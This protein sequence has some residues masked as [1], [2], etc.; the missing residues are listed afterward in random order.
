[1]ASKLNKGEK[2]SLNR[3]LLGTFL[4]GLF[5]NLISISLAQIFYSLNVVLGLFL[6]FR[7]ERPFQVPSFFWPLIIY[8][9]LSLIASLLSVNPGLSF[10]DCRELLLFLLIPATV[11]TLTSSRSLER[12]NQIILASGIINFL[13]SLINYLIS[14]QKGL[15]LRGF[16]GHYMTEAGLLMLLIAFCGAQFLFCREKKRWLWAAL[17][18]GSGYL[19]LLTLT[20]NAWLGLASA[21]LLL[22]V[23]WRPIALIFVP[24]FV[25]AIYL[26]SPMEVKKRITNTFNFYSPSSRQRIEYYRAGL[27]IIGD[28]PLFGCGPDTVELVF[29]HPKYGLSEQAKL[30]VH[31]H[32]NLLQ[33]AA[34]RGLATLLA[35]LIFIFWSFWLLLKKWPG[36]SSGGSPWIA[37]G[38]A[39]IVALFMAGLFEYNFGD[40]EV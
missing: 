25:G 28:Y 5:F 35:W 2:I 38:L 21:L 17:A 10:R 22:L 6:W 14:G 29:Q 24:F 20:R 12:V 1:M 30:N 39:C 34:E 40:S 19:L 3:F 23:L 8:S 31:L 16:M 37:S 36:R 4:A 13:Y 33:I 27:K 9:G 11:T 7:H 26:L 32:N 18:F 15:R